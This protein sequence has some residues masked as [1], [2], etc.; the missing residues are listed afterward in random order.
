MGCGCKKKHTV[1]PAAPGTPQPPPPPP[2]APDLPPIKSKPPMRVVLRELGTQRPPMT[3]PP[4][5]KNNMDA[6]LDKLSAI[7]S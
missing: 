7:K 1:A 6:L 5:P 3:V 4:A 2:E